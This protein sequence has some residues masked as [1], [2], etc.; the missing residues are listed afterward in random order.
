MKSGDLAAGV[1]VLGF[2]SA[3]L[4]WSGLAVAR[5]TRAVTALVAIGTLVLLLTY[6]F[7]LYGT[8]T[9]ARI[10][11]F[12]NVIVVGNWIPPGAAVLMGILASQRSIPRWRRHA[13]LILL[14]SLA[15]YPVARD[16]WAPHPPPGKPLFFYGV[17][18]QTTA[19]SCSP[20]SATNLLLEHNIPATEREMMDLCL[21][22][23]TG[24][25]ELGL[26]RGLK[27]KTANTD[28]DVEV[29]KTD[30]DT[31]QRTNLFP[32]IL[33]V[34]TYGEEN[35]VGGPLGTVGHAIVVYGFTDHG[36]VEIADPSAGRQRLLVTVLRDRFCGTALR[37]VRRPWLLPFTSPSV[38]CNVRP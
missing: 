8:L 4:F 19:A 10:L 26:Y 37:L 33:L 12:S 1:A 27:L 5:R 23:A 35:S 15:W 13:L 34:S 38:P 2:V 31:L 17:C 18:V 3:V 29:L 32:A 20:C 7:T 11:P 28:W 9:I 30:L 36:R 25:P 21:T 16:V 24:T 22:R 6:G 14:A